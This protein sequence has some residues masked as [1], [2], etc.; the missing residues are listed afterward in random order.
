[1]SRR[2]REKNKLVSDEA[3]RNAEI[4]AL[5]KKGARQICDIDSN[6]YGCYNDI[7]EEFEY[8]NL[9]AKDRPPSGFAA[10]SRYITELSQDKMVKQL[11]ISYNIT[12]DEAHDPGNMSS[13]LDQLE[14]AFSANHTVIALDMAGNHFGCFGPH[15]LNDHLPKHK[16]ITK[17]VPANG[18]GTC[19]KDQT[20]EI[21]SIPIRLRRMYQ[22]YICEL[23]EI[24]AKSSVTRIDLSD[25]MLTGD[26]GRKVASLKY[27]ATHY[28]QKHC[29][30]F[31]CRS[32]LI[33]SLSIASI[34][35][36]LGYYS[37]VEHLDLSDNQ[38]GLTPAYQHTV[39]G[40]RIL[41]TALSTTRTIRVLKLA[42]NALRDEEFAI[43][44]TAVKIIPTLE[45]LDLQG[46]Y[47]HG[48]GMSPVKEAIMSHGSFDHGIK[49]G[50]KDINLSYN[51]LGD[52]G[53]MY[54]RDAISRSNTLVSLKLKSCNITDSG[55]KALH[56]VLAENS[57]ILYLDVT[58]NYAKL[59]LEAETS[60]EAE[61]NRKLVDI[62]KDPMSVD[63]GKLT[64]PVYIAL[65]NKLRFLPSEALAQ[66]HSNPSF[67][68][69]RS[70][71]KESLH[72]NQPPTRRANYLEAI[73]GNLTFQNRLKASIELEKR[74]FCARIIAR[75]VMQWYI[76]VRA[77]NRIRDALRAERL[78]AA[79]S[80]DDFL[81]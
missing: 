58:E 64:K 18:F 62:R 26:T 20:L 77:R 33:N 67:N 39:D 4:L 46:N 21:T 41:M 79:S 75:H 52:E 53:V 22:D 43:I 74:M 78:L 49:L 70:T 69:D 7:K 13:F 65:K 50:L 59:V 3:K 54:M 68:V 72:S 25:N 45:V 30:V 55:M 11:D 76:E 6:E 80:V 73:K 61:A 48:I 63:T 42:R 8:L 81:L 16:M 12:L 23:A 34:S 51:P 36:G 32:N 2:K 47:C 38:I 24:L 19:F 40:I 29:T 31:K 1:M 9:S 15:P 44:S 35:E 27:F 66:L 14:V 28:L 37:S 56:A 10:V 60:A 5:A 17:R 57:S 71:M